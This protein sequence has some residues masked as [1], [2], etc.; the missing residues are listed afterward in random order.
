MSFIARDLKNLKKKTSTVP[1]EAPRLVSTSSKIS[2]SKKEATTAGPAWFD[3]PK[4]D[5][6]DPKIRDDIKLLS[7]RSALDPK[8]HYRKGDRGFSGSKYFQVGTVV[9][10]HSSYFNDRLIKKQRSTTI[11]DTLMRDA[12]RKAYLKS[13]YNRLQSNSQRRYGDSYRGVKRK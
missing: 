6:N 1:R 9:A 13:K 2:K 4:G 8:Q 11:L 10:D 5:M 3:M 12:E 7:L